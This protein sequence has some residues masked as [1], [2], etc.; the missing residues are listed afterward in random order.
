MMTNKAAPERAARPFLLSALDLQ[1]EYGISRSMAYRFLNTERL[2]VVRIGDRRFMHRDR[3]EDW[4]SAQVD[5]G[6]EVEDE[7]I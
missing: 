6:A 7:Q 4:L 1:K 2:P 5:N 3:F